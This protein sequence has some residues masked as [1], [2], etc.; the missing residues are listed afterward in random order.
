MIGSFKAIRRGRI[1]LLLPRQLD[2]SAV[3]DP[4]ILKSKSFENLMCDMKFTS[5]RLFE[6]MK[7]ELN[8]ALP[9]FASTNTDQRR[10]PF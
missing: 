4:P 9:F 8:N 2:K 5:V 3:N 10:L 7:L 1:R 6:S